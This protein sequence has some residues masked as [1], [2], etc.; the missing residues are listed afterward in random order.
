MTRKNL[1]MLAA[2]VTFCGTMTMLTSCSDVI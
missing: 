2:V 1:W